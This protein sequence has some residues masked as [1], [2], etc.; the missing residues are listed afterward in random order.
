MLGRVFLASGA[1]YQP[2]PQ[3]QPLEQ[4]A[5][6]AEVSDFGVSSAAAIGKILLRE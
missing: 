3:G 4:E 2:A 6:P 5:A 1:I